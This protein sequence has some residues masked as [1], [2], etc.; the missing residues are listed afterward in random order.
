MSNGSHLGAR[1]F[2][3]ARATGFADRAFPE[4]RA[5]LVDLP[6][7]S[8]SLAMDFACFFAARMNFRR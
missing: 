8:L 4:A 2:E 5:C 1:F 6:V 3:D 7:S